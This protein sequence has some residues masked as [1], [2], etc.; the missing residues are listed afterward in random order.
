MGKSELSSG[1]DWVIFGKLEGIQFSSMGVKATFGFE[2][3]VISGSTA[4][5]GIVGTSV[6]NCEWVSEIKAEVS[7][8]FSDN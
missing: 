4:G 5:A 8:C 3:L 6:C 7:N 2:C 1:W